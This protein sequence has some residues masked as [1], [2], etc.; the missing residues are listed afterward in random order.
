MAEQIK[1]F[2]TDKQSSFYSDFFEVYLKLLKNEFKKRDLDPEIVNIINGD[3]INVNRA[4][5]VVLKRTTSMQPPS[6]ALLNEKMVEVDG[7]KHIKSFINGALSF[8][9]S[10][11][12]GTYLEAE[13]L[14]S[15][16]F[17]IIML[18]GIKK[19]STLSKG[20][21]YGHSVVHWEETMIN[22]ADTK[23]F[24]NR[25]AINST[26]LMSSLTEL[27]EEKEEGEE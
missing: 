6:M 9:V 14:G 21:I 15:A 10:C 1:Y 24:S 19:I 18:S 7:K 13:R 25:I 3:L 11:Y 26:I 4:P 17:E 22:S 5:L 8:I 20:A 23:L 12:G 16:V 27:E 2:K